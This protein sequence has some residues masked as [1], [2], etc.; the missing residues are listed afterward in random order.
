M[1]RM[2]HKIQQSGLLVEEA[3][4]PDPSG[5]GRPEI[6]AKKKRVSSSAQQRF[7]V[8]TSRQELERQLWAN[9][10]PGRDIFGT[11]TYGDRK[12]PKSLKQIDDQCGYFRR[13]LNAAR[14]KKKLPPVVMHWAVEHLTGGGRWHIHFVMKARGSSY[15][16]IRSKW[17]YGEVADLER[18]GN[19]KNRNMSLVAA[20]MSKERADVH[21]KHVWHHTRN[22]AA[23]TV[24][25]YRV[26][27]VTELTIPPGVKVLE[28]V[29]ERTEYG[30]YRYVKYVLP[31]TAD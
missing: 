8:K 18:L 17:I 15:K 16:E 27:D 9:Y 14:A 2:I 12:Y 23:P 7:N 26:K 6:R 11:L 25:R 29:T 22:I 3:V 13:R 1:P 4:Y 21:S 24:E 28:D 19:T 20:Y 30:F 10:S 31:E 5:R